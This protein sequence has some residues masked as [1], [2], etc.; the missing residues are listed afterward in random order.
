MRSALSMREMIPGDGPR[1]A[2]LPGRSM[3]RKTAPSTFICPTMGII[4]GKYGPSLESMRTR[5]R[6]W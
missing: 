3:S 6:E 2:R 1:R 5:N 4:G